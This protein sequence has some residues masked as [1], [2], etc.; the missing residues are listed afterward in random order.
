MREMRPIL[1]AVERGSSTNSR[2]DIE[3]S[4]AWHSSCHGIPGMTAHAW[5]H[6]THQRLQLRALSRAEQVQI[7]V[8]QAVQPAGRCQAPAEW[9]SR[10]SNS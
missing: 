8:Q 5:L 4:V 10:R 6:A 9:W 1:R 2:G 3:C 7:A